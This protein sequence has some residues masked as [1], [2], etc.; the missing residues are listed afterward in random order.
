MLRVRFRA[1]EDDPR[2]ISWPVKYPF[3]CTG[4]GDGYAIVVA[5]VDEESEILKL[6]PEATHIDAE[7]CEEISF[8]SRFPC[9]KWFKQ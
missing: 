1:N 4:Y 6:W 2:P 5:Y 9:P 7:E 3:W 8:S